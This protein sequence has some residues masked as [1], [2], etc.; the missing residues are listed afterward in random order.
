MDAHLQPLVDITLSHIRDSKH[1]VSFLDDQRWGV[2]HHWLSCDVSALYPSLLHDTC[3]QVLAQ[4]LR[5]FS[6]YSTAT[7]E[8]LLL[9]T[10][11]LLK[12]NYLVFNNLFYLQVCG[13]AIAC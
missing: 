8:F 9:A 2:G 10:E 4:Y 13:A 1:L 3:V 5:T 12:H 6:A 7:R 11:F